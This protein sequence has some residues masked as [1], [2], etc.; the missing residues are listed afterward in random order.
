MGQSGVS[1]PKASGQVEVAVSAYLSVGEI[2]GRIA[3]T[4]AARGRTRRA[5][6]REDRV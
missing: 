6:G 1:P 2:F 3:L 4:I 5:S